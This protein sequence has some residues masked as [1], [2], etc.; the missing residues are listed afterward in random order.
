VSESALVLQETHKKE[1]G[2]AGGLA[3]S[4]GE[5]WIAVKKDPFGGMSAD[6]DATVIPLVGNDKYK[7]VTITP[8]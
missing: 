4:G 3:M 7:G 8:V 5:L 2:G 6:K 1:D